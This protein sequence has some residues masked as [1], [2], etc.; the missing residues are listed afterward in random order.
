MIRRSGVGN[1]V[2]ASVVEAHGSY[3]PVSEIALNSNSHI[4]RLKVVYD[5]DSYTAISIEALDGHKSLFVLS[6][7]DASA[8][9]EHQIEVDSTTYRW[10]GPYQY[11]GMK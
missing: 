10:T 4:A 11:M 7:T 3:S 5:D 1:T 9:R 6:N 2:F 8:T